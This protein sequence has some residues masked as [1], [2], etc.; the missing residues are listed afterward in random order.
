MAQTFARLGSAVVLVEMADR[1]LSRED[2]DVSE[3]VRA[4]L[5]SE[6]VR[7]ITGHKAISVEREVGGDDV[8]VCEHGENSLRIAFDAILVA[9]GRVPRVA[10]YGLEELKIPL[11]EKGKTIETDD[12]LRTPFPN[13]YACGDVAGPF[14]L[15]HAGAHQA[16]YAAV[17][18]LFGTFKKFKADYRVMPAVT[19][20]DPEVARVGL[21]EREARQQDIQFEV[22]RYELDDLDRALAEREP[23]G[24]VK[25]ITAKG[26]D[27][28]LGATCVGAHAGEWMVEFVLAMKYKI[29]LNK[30]LG[31]VHAYPTWAEA[32]KYAAG[33][34]KRAHAPQRVM[35]WLQR[36]H[37]WRR[38]ERRRADSDSE[39]SA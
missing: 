3:L 37:H 6:G 8:L 38:H 33:N 1:L 24:F 16:W 10:G 12:Y 34:W 5:Q 17:N 19:F 21:N 7:V 28:I 18:A 35:N 4:R 15:T 11:R 13:I 23:L 20:T 32:N 26:K 31:T 39:A 9:V 2:D 25:V 30:I 29:G 27:S 14:Q 36:Y 22:T